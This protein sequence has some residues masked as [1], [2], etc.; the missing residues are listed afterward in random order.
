MVQYVAIRAVVRSP[1]R[2]MGRE[3][4]AASVDYCADARRTI[5]RQRTLK[6]KPHITPLLPNPQPYCPSQ[7]GPL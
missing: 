1:P 7:G 6:N 4:G 3:K 5:C 2:A